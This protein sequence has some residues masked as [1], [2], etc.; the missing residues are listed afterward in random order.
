MTQTEEFRALVR[1]QCGDLGYSCPTC[2]VAC[3]K[4]AAESAR[5][6]ALLASLTP[7]RVVR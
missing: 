3:L 1:T 7:W 2:P 6:F 4:L 5:W